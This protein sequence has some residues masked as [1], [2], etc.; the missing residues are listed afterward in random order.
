MVNKSKNK[1]RKNEKHDY[2]KV[3][4]IHDLTKNSNDKIINEILRGYE[5][6]KLGIKT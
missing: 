6:F 3:N 1:K 4:H 2:T 5:H